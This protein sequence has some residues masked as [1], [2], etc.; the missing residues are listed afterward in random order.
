MAAGRDTVTAREYLRRLRWLDGAAVFGATAFGLVL[1]LLTAVPWYA[2]I[3]MVLVSWFGLRFIG[4][5]P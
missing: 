5:G 3:V 4:S 2:V 1:A